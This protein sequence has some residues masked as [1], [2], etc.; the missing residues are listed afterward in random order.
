M[1]I[2]AVISSKVKM[3]NTVD[4]LNLRVSDNTEFWLSVSSE[5]N[6]I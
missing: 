1:E 3:S 5:L 4:C 6:K 2:A